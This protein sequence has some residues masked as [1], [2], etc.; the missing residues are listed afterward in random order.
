MRTRWIKHASLL[1]PYLAVA[2][3]LGSS[4]AQASVATTT[5][6]NT[7]TSTTGGAIKV[8]PLSQHAYRC[9]Q[10]SP[11][12]YIE[13]V[14]TLKNQKT[15]GVSWWME[16][17]HLSSGNYNESSTLYA[18][19]Q[20]SDF[21]SGYLSPGQTATVIIGTSNCYYGYGEYFTWIV[22]GSSSSTTFA[23]QATILDCY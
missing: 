20:V 22:G 14:V 9:A 10:I 5:T 16:N 19:G 1:A 7:A 6:T 15:V 12:T 8:N 18:N 11:P 13:C 21:V 3:L 4:A 17:Q 2:L 23:P